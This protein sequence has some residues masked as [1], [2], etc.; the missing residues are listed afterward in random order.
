M[1][2]KQITGYIKLQIGAGSAN[3]APPVG[4]ALGQR[5]VN[6]PEFCKQFNDVT[7]KMEKG[8]PL[9]VVI[10]VYADKSFTFIFKQ[11]PTSYLVKKAAKLNSGSKTPGREFVGKITLAQAEEIGKQKLSDMNVD[12]L[13]SAIEQVRGTALSMGIKVEE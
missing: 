2:K 11:P 4:P 1:K 9:P 10:T 13:K 5:G 7:S 12:D 8:T 6:I 3:P